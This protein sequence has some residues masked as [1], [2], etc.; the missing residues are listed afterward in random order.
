MVNV[1]PARDALD[2]IIEE[3]IVVMVVGAR[4]P[5]GALQNRGRPFHLTSFSQ[6]QTKGTR[7]PSVM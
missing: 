2:M 3:Q 7:R 1:F 5:I 6:V 4:G